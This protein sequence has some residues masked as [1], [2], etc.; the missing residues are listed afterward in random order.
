MS[1]L[2]GLLFDYGHTLI[3]FPKY[4]KAIKASNENV[5]KILQN[6]GVT[7]NAQRVRELIDNFADREDGAVIG[8][9]EEFKEIFSILKIRKY[10]QKDL[11]EIITEHWMPFIQYAHVRRGAKELLEYLKT[12]G[13]KLGVVANIWS[14]GMDPVLK[15]LKLQQYFD[16]TLASVDIGFQKPDPKIFNLALDNLKLAPEQTIMV[17]DNP[18]TDIQGAH[19]LGMVTVRLKRGPHRNNPDLVKPDFKIRNLSSLISIVNEHFT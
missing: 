11:R 17:G 15:R 6:L 12:H 4:E 5:Q 1:R 8:M 10:R 13:Y 3:W 9:E 16:I 14:E 2:K 7:I 18:R 19:E